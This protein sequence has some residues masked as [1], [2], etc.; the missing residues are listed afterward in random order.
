MQGDQHAAADAD[1]VDGD[2]GESHP[3]QAGEEKG[4]SPANEGKRSDQRPQRHPGPRRDHD[5]DYQ[6]QAGGLG[7]RSAHSRHAANRSQSTQPR[8]L[9]PH[10]TTNL[11]HTIGKSIEVASCLLRP[12]SPCLIAQGRLMR[13]PLGSVCLSTAS[14]E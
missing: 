13:L 1:L 9:I 3:K 14:I 6:A 11:T 2:V 12:A 10:H 7:D 8:L 5:G 4:L